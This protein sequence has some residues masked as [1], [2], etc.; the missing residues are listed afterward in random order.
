MAKVK[1]IKPASYNPR[2]ITQKQ[3]DSLA[4]SMAEFGDLSGIVV[5]KKT[6][7]LIGGHQR[8]KCLDPEWSIE[9]SPYSDNSGT[10]AIGYIDTHSGRIAYR[11]VVWSLQKEKAANLAANNQGGENDDAKVLDILKELKDVGDIDLD[12]TGLGHLDI[13]K[14]LPVDEEDENESTDMPSYK[15]HDCPDCGQKHTMR[16]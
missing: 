8:L 3:L 6:G 15:T 11:E 10:V 7:N 16:K 12:L 5:N 13:D 4:K 9:I 1:D 14:L 2:K